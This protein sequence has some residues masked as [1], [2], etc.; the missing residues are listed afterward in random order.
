M[1][2]LE[3]LMS[4]A[5]GRSPYDNVF[6]G[7]GP[8]RSQDSTQIYDDRGRPVNPETRRINR[9]I[10][11]S[12]NEVMLVIGV[13]EPERTQETEGQATARRHHEYEDQTGRN[14]LLVGGVLE[15]AGVWGINGLRHR[16]LLYKQ[17]AQ[18][19]FHHL[20]LLQK[21]RQSW[22]S[23]LLDG[24]PAYLAGN[25][26]DNGLLSTTGAFITDVIFPNHKD[27]PSWTGY[28][29]GYLQMHLGIY[30]FLQRV[31]LISS[32]QW[33]PSWKFFVPG[34]NVSPIIVPPLP[35]SFTRQSIG[36]WLTAFAM[37]AAPFAAYYAYWKAQNWITRALR[38]KIHQYLPRPYNSAA[39][40]RI[41]EALLPPPPAASP[42]SPQP[43]GMSSEEQPRNGGDM[44]RDDSTLRIREGRT[45]SDGVPPAGALRRQSTISARGDDFGSD[46]EE[47]D[48]I[49][50]TLISFDVEATE[51]TDAT[52]GVWSA[53]LRPNVSENSKP[54]TGWV[55]LYRENALT[56][57]PSIMGAHTLAKF[58]AR[59]LTAPLQCL[60]WTGIAVNYLAR[61][62]GC[63][64]DAFFDLGFG[65]PFFSWQR[66]VNIVGVELIHF[67]F[68]VEASTWT[69]A[70]SYKYLYTEEGWIKRE[71]EGKDDEP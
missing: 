53:E 19:P 20:Y 51:S 71:E 5:L 8:P 45:Q 32:A 40:R 2:Q 10:I 69:S 21:S 17:Y 68:E 16:I 66:L 57:L 13:A 55:P 43:N 64:V 47:G 50:A 26:L 24:F 41:R 33:F 22:S 31:G 67:I 4:Q 35:L 29:R 23:Y 30:S 52:P 14:M 27:F 3:P 11:R 61:G 49:S 37:G 15:A 62:D 36:A 48:V 7:E 12:H 60:A 18:I 42:V 70:V 9:D 65:P 63:A 56:L 46:D 28:V 6:Q 39:R 58:P 1:G 59:I 34:S 44:N 38:M 25:A 54:G